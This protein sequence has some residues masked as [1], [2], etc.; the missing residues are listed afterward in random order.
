MPYI[1]EAMIVTVTTKGK[2]RPRRFKGICRLAD[3]LGVSRQHVYEVLIG[4][5]I[6]PRV[7]AAARQSA[8]LLPSMK[9][10]AERATTK[11]RA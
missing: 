5:R 6:S 8:A 3:S 10:A 7:L 2:Q 11:R 9:R 1:S 4:R